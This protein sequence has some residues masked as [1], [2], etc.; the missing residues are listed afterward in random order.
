MK[1]TMMMLLLLLV[2]IF[3]VTMATDWTV[4]TAKT[5]ANS[6]IDTSNTYSWWGTKSRL[7]LWYYY[8]DSVKA[9]IHVDYSYNGT[10]WTNDVYTDSLI[11]TGAAGWKEIV[12][13]STILDRAPGYKYHRIRF[14]ARSADN[15]VTS[16]TYDLTIKYN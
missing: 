3:T 15:G 12:V 14:A 1:R 10:T 4:R 6:V 8:R 16:A 11:G 5:Y 9:D 13:R 2:V 7:S